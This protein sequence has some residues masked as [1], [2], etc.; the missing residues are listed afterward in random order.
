MQ[1]KFEAS[2]KTLTASL[3]ITASF[4]DVTSGQL[5]KLEIHG[6]WN[7]CRGMVFLDGVYIGSIQKEPG[8]SKLALNPAVSHLS[9]SVRPA[10]R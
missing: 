1:L 9:L 3:G 10:A 4:T 7:K 6:N 8:T 5:T 2:T